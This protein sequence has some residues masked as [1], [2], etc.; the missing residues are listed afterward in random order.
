MK[1]VAIESQKG[2]VGKTT[3]A[4]NLA[5]AAE[6]DG[7]PTAIIDLDPQ[8]SA[9]RWKELR[10]DAGPAVVSAQANRL[11]QILATAQESGAKLVII[12]TAPNSEGTILIAARSADLVLI[13]CKPG[14]LDI[15]SIEIT[16]DLVK[17]AAKKDPNVVM[18][19]VPPVGGQ[20][21][22][23]AE[24]IRKSYSANIVPIMVSHRASYGHALTAGQSVQ[25]FEP[26]GKASQEIV[27]LYKWMRRSV[28]L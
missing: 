5:V 13:P 20:G 7:K 25:E 18:T 3:L 12:D 23:A 9:T 11:K 2:G 10:P 24:V 16:I 15:H 21:E 27:Q 22:R 14:I 19:M 26:D 17:T 6:R 28:G 8:V 1:I 4:I